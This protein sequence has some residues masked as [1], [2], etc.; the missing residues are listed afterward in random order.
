MSW[1]YQNPV[2]VQFGVGA[3]DQV[4]PAIA[5]R[6]WALVTYD[7]D[8]F[9]ALGQR[10]AR[11]AGPPVTIVD[12]IQANPD[13]ADLGGVCRRFA[14]AGR[15]GV[16]VALGGGSV[17]DAAKVLA[18]AGGDFAAVRAHLVD[19][20]PLDAG[21]VLPVLAVP[22]T[23][24]TGSEVTCWAT[25]WDAAGGRKYS[26]AHPGLYPEAAIVDPALTLAA[27]HGLTLAT[28]LDALS[29]ALESLWNVNANPVSAQ[30]AIAAAR[31][32]LDVLPR[33]LE[34]PGDVALRARQSQASLLA[35]LAFS[36][37]KTALAHNISY[38]VTLRHGT[39][40]GIACS[41]SLP[42]V[43]RWAIGRD[44]ACDERLAAIFGPDLP[45]G[46]DRLQR[47]LEDLGV[48]TDPAAH[49]LAPGEWVR[50]VDK[51]FAGERGR[52]FI[53]RRELAAE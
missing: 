41:F 2:R 42:Q 27:P 43:M 13:F 22:T 21:R 29:H 40:H 49:G 23:A 15:T 4:A 30:F 46:A 17:I 6:P 53:G 37:T 31:E 1:A 20:T 39:A 48:P 50:L 14:A 10:I 18:A 12:D 25:V 16:V 24:G 44:P 45:A 26:I 34:Q 11:Q 36:N 38:D 52:N 33:L 8:L 7:M 5:G 9:R 51:A 3:L 28:G 32:V 35:G 19:G 47:F